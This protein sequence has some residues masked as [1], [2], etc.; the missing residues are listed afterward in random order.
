MEPL[1]SL[2]K[3]P[4]KDIA[5]TPIAYALY[6]I[7]LV[8][9]SVIVGQQVSIGSSKSDCQATVTRL[10]QDIKEERL[11]KDEVFK[12]Y[13]VERQTNKAIQQ[14]VDSTVIENYK[15]IKK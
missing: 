8:L 3:I 11:I 12:A 2:N 7:V 15:T 9:V 5:Q 13:L 6:V 4:V 10:E 1:D 14:T